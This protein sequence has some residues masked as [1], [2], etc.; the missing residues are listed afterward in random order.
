MGRPI[1]TS[2]TLGAAVAN[3]ISLT[4][5][6]AAAPLLLNGA[7]VVKGVAVLDVPRRIIITSS[8]NDSGI[9]FKITGTSRPEMGGAVF[10][11]TVA[12]TNAGIAASTQDFATV[13][14]IVPSGAVAA[15]VTAGTNT[16][17]S[18]P[19]VAW[20][21]N[22]R[23]GFQVSVA[24]NVISGAPNWQLDYTQDDVFGTWL[25]PGVPFPRPIKS[26][27]PN[28]SNQVGNS[29]GVINWPV[30]ASRLTLIA[31]GQVQLTQTQEGD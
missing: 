28:L 2:L 8:G 12:G 31:I 20:D 9:T 10:S 11:E 25:P 22:V 21:Q 23:T 27:D 29:D 14:S 15:N 19:W 16:T 5:A 1:V 13:T 18:G 3:G 6:P 17:A 24:G 30:R 7:S 26:N 4:Q